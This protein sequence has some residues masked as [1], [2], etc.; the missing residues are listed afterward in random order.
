MAYILKLRWKVGNQE[1]EYLITSAS[2]ETLVGRSSECTVVLADQYVSRRHAL[3]SY[4]VDGPD[5]KSFFLR[6]ISKSTHIRFEQP[7]DLGSLTCEQRIALKVGYMFAVGKTVMKVAS[8]EKEPTPELQLICANCK[9]VVLASAF[10][11]PWCG[12]N[13]A[14]GET[15]YGNLPDD[16]GSAGQ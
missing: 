15:F 5:R 13:L 11:C 2:P 4:E 6:N 9:H 10:D 12:S 16:S 3:I 8:I 7:A 14:H 1:Q